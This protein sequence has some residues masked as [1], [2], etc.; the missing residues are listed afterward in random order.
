MYRFGLVA[1]NVR[2]LAGAEVAPPQPAGGV[3]VGQMNGW[4][5]T[6]ARPTLPE[7][8]AAHRTPTRTEYRII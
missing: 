2:S 7:S 1:L 8:R 4:L 6:C 5:Q 3:G